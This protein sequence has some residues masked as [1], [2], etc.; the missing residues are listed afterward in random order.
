MKTSM[1]KLEQSR[2]R[3]TVEVGADVLEKALEQAYR[4]TGKKIS[5]PGF[6]RGKA[7][8]KI[9]ELN[10]GPR[11]FLEEAL[12]ILLPEAFE[13]AVQEAEIRP[14][15]RPEADIE[16]AELGVGATFLFE[17]DIYPQIR[18]GNYRGLEVERE[19]VQISDEDVWEVLK[20]QQERSAQLVVVDSRTTVEKGDFAVVDFRGYIEGQAFSG[21]AAENRTIEIGSGHSIPGFEE[22][23]IGAS[24]GQS[25]EIT[26]TFPQEYH[27]AGLAGKEAVF[28]VTVK[29]LKKK[30]LPEIDDEFAKDISEYETLDELKEE[31]RKNLEDDATRRTNIQLE[32][33]ILELIAQDSAVEVPRS[34]IEHQAEHLVDDLL[35]EMRR[36]GID[37]EKYLELTGESRE[38][39]REELEPQALA[40]ITYDLIL[41]SVAEREG[42]LVSEEEVTKRIEEYLNHDGELEPELEKNLRQYWEQQKE[43]IRLSLERERTIDLIVKEA[44]ITDIFPGAGENS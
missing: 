44:R 18:L 17:V 28:Q 1:E 22:Q 37:E 30:V 16:E 38:S 24:V 8:R 7:P 21:G 33:R 36:Q 23:L 3:F 34:M 20:E 19:I 43:N 25:Q 14:V 11:V 35:R 15:G 6:R 32:N 40:Q 12:D 13:Q 31:I 10:Y 42:I 41:E 26:V 29:E 27:T 2:V 4:R 39:L 9:I 5:I